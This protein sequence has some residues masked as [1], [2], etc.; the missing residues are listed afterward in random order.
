M[1]S[2]TEFLQDLKAL[3]G[4][5]LFCVVIV[6][7]YFIGKP[8]L[9]LQLFSGLILAYVLTFGIRTFYFRLRPDKEKYHNYFEKINASSFPSMHAMRASVFAT[10]LVLFFNNNFLTVLFV[11]CAAGVGISRVLTK[12]HHTSDVIVGWIFGVIVALFDVWLVAKFIS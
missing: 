9:A 4:A 7:S 2:K 11:V 12:R 10:L 1:A 3:A 6:I 8:V 5:P